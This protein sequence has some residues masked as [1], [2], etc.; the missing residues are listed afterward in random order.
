MPCSVR[1]RP[2]VFGMKTGM[3]LFDPK[4]PGSYIQGRI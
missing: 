1:H 3:Q 4:I 2:S